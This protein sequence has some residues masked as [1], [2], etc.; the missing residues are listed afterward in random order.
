MLLTACTYP[1][2]K[3]PLVSS[4]NFQQ[5]NTSGEFKL[6]IHL[7]FMHDIYFWEVVECKEWPKTSSDGELWNI[8]E[9]EK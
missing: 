5:G 1:A 4:D 9:G 6:F 8:T 7:D 3:N 2:F